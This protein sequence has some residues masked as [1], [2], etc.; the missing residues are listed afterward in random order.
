MGQT[1]TVH[2]VTGR[3]DDQ[4]PSVHPRVLVCP[5][6]YV[7]DGVAYKGQTFLPHSSGCWTSKV[8]VPADS[9]SGEGQLPGSQTAVFSLCPHVEGGTT[10]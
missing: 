1:G 6:C 3:C 7:T 10:P 2:H 8:K 5:G 4:H 9:M